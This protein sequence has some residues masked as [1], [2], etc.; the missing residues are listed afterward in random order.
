MF[1]DCK[2]GMVNY[3]EKEYNH[4]IIVHVDGSVTPRKK[5]ISRK[6]YGT[7]HILAQE[8][9]EPLL[10]EKPEV[11]IV[12]S[13]VHGALEL[14]E[15]SIEIDVIVLPTCKAVEKYNQ[16]REEGKKVAAIVHVTC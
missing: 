3:D 5:E 11:I 4:D 8:E 15:I 7:S 6:K 1:Q 2:F 14:G 10:D 13:G 9:I 12:G 16:L